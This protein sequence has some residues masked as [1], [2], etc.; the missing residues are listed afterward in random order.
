MDQKYDL[1]IYFN[2]LYLSCKYQIYENTHKLTIFLLPYK[3]NYKND[4]NLK[5]V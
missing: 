3:L 5:N 4:S 2:K 1:E